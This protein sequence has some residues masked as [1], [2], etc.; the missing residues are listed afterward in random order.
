MIGSTEFFLYPSIPELPTYWE[1]FW[2]Q[3][4][5]AVPGFYTMTI[6]IL[7]GIVALLNYRKTKNRDTLVYFGL[8]ITVGYL[9]LL[10]GL[11]SCIN[12]KT[13][14]EILH[15]YTY[16]IV[17]F[18]SQ[19][20]YMVYYIVTLKKSKS[21]LIF[22]YINLFVIFWA[23]Y[24]LFTETAYKN[25]YLEYYF[26]IYPV[27]E[28]PIRIW[29][30]FS[31]LGYILVCIPAYF[32]LSQEDRK[33]V[34]KT[35]LLGLYIL[36]LLLFTNIFSIYGIEFLPL[37]SYTFIPL[38]VIAWGYYKSD[39]MN[40]KTILLKNGRIFYTSSIFMTVILFG[41]LFVALFI[42]NPNVSNNLFTKY[43]YFP[44]LSFS[45]SV[46][47]SILVAASNPNSQKN[48]YGA[49]AILASSFLQLNLFFFSLKLDPIILQRIE[50]FI[51]QFFPLFLMGIYRFSY[52]FMG[53]NPGKKKFLFDLVSILCICFAFTP[54]L[55]NGYYEYYFG[56]F[57]Q[58]GIILKI[59]TLFSFIA[60]I[61]I[62]IDFL[63]LKNKSLNESL[64]VTSFL[65][66]S[67]LLIFNIPASLGFELYPL[68]NFQFIP[69][70]MIGYSLSRKGGLI[71]FKESYK[72]TTSL[73]LF[74]GF[75]IFI[76][77]IIYYNTFDKILDKNQVILYVLFLSIV[78]FL[79]FLIISLLITRPILI[80]MQENSEEQYKLQKEI[81]S[82]IK[83]IDNSNREI[84]RIN[85]IQS[86]INSTLDINY[87]FDLISDYI[88]EK[89]Q[90]NFILL[91]IQNN[92]N[93]TIYVFGFKNKSEE[94]DADLK[95][96][97]NNY[98]VSI[99][100][101]SSLI[102]RIY[103]WNKYFEFDKLPNHW[104][105]NKSE[106]S[107][108]S[109]FN[110]NKT[111]VLPI[112]INQ[113]K[114]GML[115]I[116]KENT[117][118]E[119]NNINFLNNINSILASSLYRS[120]LYQEAIEAKKYSDDLTEE[121]K[122]INNVNQTINSNTDLK[123]I[124]EKIM[125]HY[126]NKFG[127]DGY[128]IFSIDNDLAFLKTTNILLDKKT[129]NESWKNNSFPIEKSFIQHFVKRNKILYIRRIPKF[130]T[131]RYDLKVLEPLNLESFIGIPLMV[132][133]EIIGFIF[134]TKLSRDTINLNK[135][136]VKEISL[137]TKQITSALQKSFMIQ[138][139]QD[140]NQKNMK[141]AKELENLN[142]I[143][144]KFNETTELDTLISYLE[145]FFQENYD[146]PFFSISLIDKE[147]D[148]TYLMASNI[149]S[150]LSDKSKIEILNNVKINLS[151]KSGGHFLAYEFKKH[152][153]ISKINRSKTPENELQVIDLL[154]VK[155]M[156]I[157]PLLIKNE[158]IGFLDLMDN[159]PLIRNKKS[160]VEI[161]KFINQFSISIINVELIQNLNTA[162]KNLKESQEQLIQ[163][164]K[165]A[166]LG[167]L[168]SGV[169]HEINTP[170]GAI[171]ATIKSLEA[172]MENVLSKYPNIWEESTK[173]EW[174][175]IQS[176][177]NKSKSSTASLSTKEERT[178]R[179]EL[180]SKLTSMGIENP[181][182]IADDLVDIGIFNINENLELLFKKENIT[183]TID[184][185][186]NLA[187][188]QNKTRIIQQAVDKASKIV[189]ALKNYAHFDA[190]DEK[191]LFSIQEG[192]ET[193]LTIYENSL[194]QGI[195]IEKNYNNSSPIFCFPDELNQIWTNLIHNAIQ[196]MNYSGK[197][198]ISILKES[199]S[200]RRTQPKSILSESDLVVTIEDNGPGIPPEIQD[201]IFDAFFTTK[202]RGEGSGLGLHIT[203]QIV[204]KHGG[205]I[206]LDTEPG[207]TKFH[208]RLPF[209]TEKN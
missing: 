60:F 151:E 44:L 67:L 115:I 52:S 125:H 122:I 209:L 186:C 61:S 17:L 35:I 134:F 16:W 64:I 202:S 94:L 145:K 106:Q 170:L 63:K 143:S 204:D 57:S 96:Y 32:K 130:N 190:T 193:V 136:K 65:F 27:A 68:G 128:A 66:Y 80:N 55:M 205:E 178:I 110:V 101:K 69:A 38:M 161:E 25:E 91:L 169:A 26:G 150:K 123:T 124:M 83:S 139:L 199:I 87:I 86:K 93:N 4:H 129:Q 76:F 75:F 79:I 85:L 49:L 73:N 152:F 175:I 173:Q 163:S 117:N 189:F 42:L 138:D 112:E 9:G 147:T 51:Y 159:K 45:A 184:F 185:I 176:I 119:E 78:L 195:E 109:I 182:D 104:G 99:K 198:T 118:N 179:R 88:V 30:L 10:L 111:I 89:F 177:L 31:G 208:V 70:L 29:S 74:S 180:E 90:S 156:V 207:S 11:R 54:F 144:K 135:L 36:P 206:D 187:G 105:T 191:Q 47:I 41:L 131:G 126:Q 18:S 201:R 141:V 166:A 3:L 43:S 23:M 132:K 58:G 46:I 2:H 92:K 168:V 33:N 97:I 81:D 1:Y 39:W 72:I 108:L 148:T 34:N 53:V 98:K 181:E 59:L 200:R 100:D 140:S 155:S 14:W 146:Y 107:I 56:Y 149:E 37:G 28:L 188:L 24:A 13:I 153:N 5:F 157:F 15:K 171:K 82:S 116:S 160:I 6:G 142:Y 8:F 167:Q 196:A 197:I 114:Y 154:D 12:N 192:I 95:N 203:K 48:L 62:F 194:K 22:S 40:F 113:I 50:Q 164:E 174:E 103:N 127:L 71:Q 84:E 19:F 165:M 162:Y 137:F 77:A 120:S 20:G 121:L 102:A 158:V 7:L 183:E 21:L 172:G 133:E